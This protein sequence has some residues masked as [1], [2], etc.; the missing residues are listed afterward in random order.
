MYVLIIYGIVSILAMLSICFTNKRNKKLELSLFVLLMVFFA[1]RFPLGTDIDTYNEIYS[2]TTN[3]FV[4]AIQGIPYPDNIGYNVFMTLAKKLNLNFNG[5]MLYFNLIIGLII[6]IICYKKSENLLISLVI[7]IGSG[8]IQVYYS[9]MLRQMIVMALFLYAFYY[10]LENNNYFM[11]YLI[12][13]IAISFQWI[14]LVLLFIPLVKLFYEKSNTK[15]KI[16][17][18]IIVASILFLI[19]VFIVPKYAYIVPGR[20]GQYLYAD[21][22]SPIGLLSRIAVL[23]A[24]LVPY[25]F[26]NKNNLSNFDKFSVYL[27]CISL[28]IYIILSQNAIFSR[29]SDMI[30]IIE[31]ILVPKL[32]INIEHKKKRILSM[33]VLIGVNFIFLFTDLNYIASQSL[34]NSSIKEYP[35]I[36]VWEKIDFNKLFSDY[37]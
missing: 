32:I 12:V 26:T 20:F 11:Y 34:K 18:P 15:V 35:L 25:Y 22:F 7:L 30:S 2:N 21:V 4:S 5:F 3:S 27:C 37:E 14:A 31:I 36:Y 24:V 8:I 28:L 29:V 10:C 13:C 23:F 9:G 19:M 17:L 16:I 6:G 1:L 33:I